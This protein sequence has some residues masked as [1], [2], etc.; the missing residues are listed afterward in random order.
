MCGNVLARNGTILAIAL[1]L[2]F[3]LPAVPAAAEGKFQADPVTGCKVW[4][5]NPQPNETFTWSGT[6]KE[7]Y[8]SGPGIFEWLVDGKV[9]E[10]FE[11]VMR[12]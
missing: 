10:R 5:P 12:R 3:S 7:G 8:L 2:L 11:G 1:L 4:N 6:C 9:A